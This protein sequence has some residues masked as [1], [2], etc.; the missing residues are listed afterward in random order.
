MHL[1]SLRE[2]AVRGRGAI[3]THEVVRV[4]APEP[5]GPLPPLRADPLSALV[6][7]DDYPP[8]GIDRVVYR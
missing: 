6:A 3:T 1:H 4:R 2:A 8:A 7:V 5:T